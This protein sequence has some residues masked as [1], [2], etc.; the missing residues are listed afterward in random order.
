MTVWRRPRTG[1]AW[2]RRSSPASFGRARHRASVM[3]LLISEIVAAVDQEG[4]GR[5][6]HDLSD[7]TDVNGSLNSDRVIRSARGQRGANRGSSRDAACAHHSRLPSGGP[8]CGQETARRRHFVA[9]R[10]NASRYAERRAH[11]RYRHGGE[12]TDARSTRRGCRLHSLKSLRLTSGVRLSPSHI[13]MTLVR[14]RPQQKLGLT[15]TR[16]PVPHDGHERHAA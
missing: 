7:R 9:G 13:D 14:T 11:G 10:G 2:H 15:L 12:K 6:L 3:P 8:V 1:T 5:E 4:A 16:E